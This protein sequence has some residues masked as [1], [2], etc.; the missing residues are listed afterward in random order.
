MGLD[1][2]AAAFGD[3]VPKFVRV[4]NRIAG[5]IREPTVAEIGAHRGLLAVSALRVEN[6]ELFVHHVSPGA[7]LRQPSDV[8][9]AYHDAS[10]SNV[11]AD[12]STIV[13]AARTNSAS[14][15]RLHQLFR[16][17]GPFTDAN[18]RCGRVLRMWQLMRGSRQDLAEV[19]RLDLLDVHHPL[20]S[21]VV[22]R[23]IM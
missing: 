4:S 13:E 15:Y 2:H 10:Q 23:S 6:L 5:I 19:A 17:L 11:R 12:L 21:D 16:M 22:G 3:W 8:E 20:H 1:I 7:A 9:V 18:G 14:A